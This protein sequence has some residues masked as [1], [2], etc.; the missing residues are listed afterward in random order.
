MQSRSCVTILWKHITT[1]LP[2]NRVHN[3]CARRNCDIPK[4]EVVSQLCENTSQLSLT[5]RQTVSTPAEW[6]AHHIPNVFA[7]TSWTPRFQQF[8]VRQFARVFVNKPKTG[9]DVKTHSKA[10]RRGTDRLIRFHLTNLVNGPRAP[11]LSAE[12]PLFVCTCARWAIVF[13]S[14]SFWSLVASSPFPASSS[15]RRNWVQVSRESCRCDLRPVLPRIAG[16]CVVHPWPFKDSR[17]IPAWACVPGARFWDDRRGGSVSRTEHVDDA[18]SRGFVLAL[19]VSL[20]LDGTTLS[21]TKH[22]F[23]MI[24]V[25]AHTPL[26]DVH[27]EVTFCN[28]IEIIQKFLKYHDSN[29]SRLGLSKN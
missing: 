29:C 27:L 20:L 9:P 8:E 22:P 3:L 7:S 19:P 24:F 16:V 11:P 18:S 5:L 14:L 15:A 21:S 1:Q 4:A 25:L 23:Q 13:T 6:L 12:F 26:H 2:T 10:H 17:E 28:T